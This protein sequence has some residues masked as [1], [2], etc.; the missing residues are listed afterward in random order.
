MIYHYL[1]PN[2]LEDIASKKLLAV[3]ATG[4]LL[5][6]LVELF[7]AVADEVMDEFEA[8][9]VIEDEVLL[10][11]PVDVVAIPLILES[12]P[13]FVAEFVIGNNANLLQVA[14]NCITLCSC[15]CSCPLLLLCIEMSFV[16]E[17]FVITG[18]DDFIE[19]ISEYRSCGIITDNRAWCLST[20]LFE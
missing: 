19:A 1:P 18:I 2:Q 9:K 3:L 16:V 8:L 15:C 10:P 12:R 4:D 13:R 14:D 7:D 11:V 6:L 20:A 17:L 5:R